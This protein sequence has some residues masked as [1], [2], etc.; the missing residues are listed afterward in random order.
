MN[1]KKNGVQISLY[2]YHGPKEHNARH[3]HMLVILKLWQT[4]WGFHIL[5]KDVMILFLRSVF[6]FDRY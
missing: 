1:F 2:G 3:G 5:K 6:H 4:E